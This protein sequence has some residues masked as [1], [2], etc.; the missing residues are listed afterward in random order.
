MGWI[1]IIGAFICVLL[2]NYIGAISLL[3]IG[4]IIGDL[5]NMS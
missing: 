4:F 1:W 2:N 3:L 5:G